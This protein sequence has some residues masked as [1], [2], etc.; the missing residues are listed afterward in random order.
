MKKDVIAR[1][2][3]DKTITGEFNILINMIK[4]NYIYFDSYVNF[5]KQNMVKDNKYLFRMLFYMRDC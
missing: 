5:I 3:Y 4:F 2:L 1:M